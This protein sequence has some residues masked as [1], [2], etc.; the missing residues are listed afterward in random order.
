MNPNL[1]VTT[2]CR[3]SPEQLGRVKKRSIHCDKLYHKTKLVHTNITTQLP[4]NQPENLPYELCCM[5]LGI[6][7]IAVYY[8]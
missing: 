3:Q 4:N 7:M 5:D 1:K 8:S 6:I 2:L